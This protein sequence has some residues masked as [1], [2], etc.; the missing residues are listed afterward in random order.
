VGLAVQLGRPEFGGESSKRQGYHPLLDWLSNFVAQI[1]LL[2][3]YTS[4]FVKDFMDDAD[5]DWSLGNLSFFKLSVAP[6]RRAE[7]VRIRASGFTL[8]G[9]KY[10]RSTASYEHVLN[11][12]TCV[13]YLFDPSTWNHFSKYSVTPPWSE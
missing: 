7:P 12:R 4:S 2:R 13:R 3:N 11:I 9:C 10:W 1:P 6:R 5:H 8:H